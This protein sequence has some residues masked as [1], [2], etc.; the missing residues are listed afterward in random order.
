[1]R[2]DEG[3]IFYLDKRFYKSVYK[4]LSQYSNI[5]Q[6]NCFRRGSFILFFQLNWFY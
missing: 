4:S 3:D 2:E 5:G 1:M 6:T